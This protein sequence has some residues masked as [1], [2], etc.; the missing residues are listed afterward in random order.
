MNNPDEINEIRH[1]VLVM[2]VA[3]LLFI[4]VALPLLLCTSTHNRFGSLCTWWKRAL[5]HHPQLV[6]KLVVE[7]ALL[8]V[9][10]AQDE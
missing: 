8:P 5:Q 1:N 6:C 3:A 10:A 2:D 9:L 4:V 7:V